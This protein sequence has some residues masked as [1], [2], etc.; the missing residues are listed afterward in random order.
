MKRLHLNQIEPFYAITNE[1]EHTEKIIY[2]RASKHFNIQRAA[3]YRIS[4]E[5]NIMII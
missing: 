3:L 5:T 2:L 4:H 1:E